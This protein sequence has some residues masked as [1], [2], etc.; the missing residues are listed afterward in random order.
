ME[1]EQVRLQR[2]VDSKGQFTV[3]IAAVPKEEPETN[4]WYA[5]VW[6]RVRNIRPVSFGMKH[7]LSVRQDSAIATTVVFSASV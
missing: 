6:N 4:R 3:T 5:D 7:V 2:Y 1:T